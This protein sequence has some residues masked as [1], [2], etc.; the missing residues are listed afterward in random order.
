MS[1]VVDN[2]VQ[3]ADVSTIP[4]NPYGVVGEFTSADGVVEATVQAYD[5]G[6][7]KLD[8][9]SPFPLHG[10]DEAMH[11]PRSIL[12]WI[13]VCCGAA[14]LTFGFL[15]QW[16]TGGIDY[17]LV[18]AGKPFFAFESSVP[19]MFEC[20]IL[21]SAF[22]SLI[23]MLALNGLPRLH[24]PSFKAKRF[25]RATDDRFLLVIQANDPRFNAA[26]CAD[27]LRS[28]G[29]VSTELVED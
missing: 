12:G 20:T 14:G 27:F 10:I 29:A 13:V 22:G 11:A 7:R 28:V 25:E 5:A 18:I 23:G 21:F 4:A 16:W 19:V 6:Y 2:P 3:T 8:V 1:Q 24:H 17:P 15:L 9:M 26:E